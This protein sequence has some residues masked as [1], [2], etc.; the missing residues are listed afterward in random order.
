MNTELHFCYIC[1]VFLVGGLDSGRPQ[2]SRLVDSWSFLQR[3]YPL[4]SLTPS[5][6]NSSTRLPELCPMSNCGSLHCLS[7]LLGGASLRG[8]VCQAPICKHNKAPTIM[9]GIGSCPWI[10]LKLGQPSAV[11][12]LSLR[13]IPVPEPPLGRANS[14]WK[15]LWAFFL[16]SFC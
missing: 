4:G 8:Q 3:F 15:I 1:L 2:G 13:S 7:Q 14:S 10:G 5:S 11:Y 9:S 12:S 6:P 16:Y